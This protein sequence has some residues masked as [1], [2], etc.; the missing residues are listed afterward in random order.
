[1]SPISPNPDPIR[2]AQQQLDVI[3]KDAVAPELAACWDALS[4]LGEV[5]ARE[6]MTKLIGWLVQ[7]TQEATNEI[8]EN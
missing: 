7:R 2:L 3:I 8:V 5:E 4:S 1:M 6:E